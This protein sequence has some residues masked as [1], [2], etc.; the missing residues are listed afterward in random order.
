MLKY[1]GYKQ[2]KG[3]NQDSQCEKDGKKKD[4]TTTNKE[5]HRNTAF[6]TKT[7]K[8]R[9]VIKPRVPSG[10]HQVITILAPHEA[11]VIL[12]INLSK[13]KERRN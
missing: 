12:P 9:T 11:P 2:N 5:I 6:K 1:K 7:W 4:K 8:K 3:T 13:S 10:A